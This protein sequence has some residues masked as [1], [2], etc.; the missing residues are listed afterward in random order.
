V[1]I[2]ENWL[3]RLKEEGARLKANELIFTA[4]EDLDSAAQ[5]EMLDAFID[6]SGGLL[7]AEERGHRKR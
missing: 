2:E 3:N 4:W 1:A 6:A 7:D 5:L